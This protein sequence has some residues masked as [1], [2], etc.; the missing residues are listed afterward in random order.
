MTVCEGKYHQVK[1]MFQ[2]RGRTVL[3]LK[4]LSFGGVALDASLAPGQWRE[5]TEQE[6]RTLRGAAE[7]SANG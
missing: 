2:A 1:R 4:R 6:L 3:A 5:L 7:G